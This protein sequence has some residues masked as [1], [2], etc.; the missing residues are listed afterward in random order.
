MGPTAL[1]TGLKIIL[2]QYFQF[3]VLSGIQTDL[4]STEM[5]DYFRTKPKYRDLKTNCDFYN[6]PSICTN[7]P[8]SVDFEEIFVSSYLN[9]Y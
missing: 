9:L 4:R 3:S 6:V 2:Q 8:G 5:L 7:L 1:F